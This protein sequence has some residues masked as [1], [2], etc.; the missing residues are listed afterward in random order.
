MA[1]LIPNVIYTARLAALPSSNDQVYEI[2]YNTGSGTLGDVKA[3]MM[4]Y[5]GTSAGAF[6]LGMCRVRVAPDGSKIYIGETSEIEWA[7]NCYLTIVDDFD[8]HARHVHVDSSGTLFMDVDIAFSDQHTAFSPVPVLGSHAVVWLTGATVDVEFDASDSWVFDSTISG[9][10]WTAPGASASSGMTSATPTITYNAAGIYRVLCTVTAANAKTAVGVRYV[11]VYDDDN[12]PATVFQ[13]ANC[14]GSVDSG[15]WMFDVTMQAEASLSEIRERTLVILFAKDYYNGVEQSI[16][17]IEGRENIIAVGRVGPSESIRWDPV[18]GQVHF[19]VYGPH[20]WMNKMKVSATQLEFSTAPGNWNQVTNLSV[21]RALW[22]LMHWR[23]TAT[24]VMDFYPSGDTRYDDK[25]ASLANYLWSQLTEIAGTKIMAHVLCDRYGRMFAEID[26]QMVPEVSRSAF[27]TVMT[28]TEDDWMDVI[29]FE[30]ATAHDVGQVNLS[31]RFVNSSGASVTLYSL[32]PGHLP[33]RYGEAAAPIDGMLAAS[34]AQSNQMAGLYLGWKC[35]PFPGIPLKLPQNNRMIDICPRQ[36]LDITIAAEDTPRGVPYSGNII[37]R[38]VA[39]PYDADARWLNVAINSEGET[40]EEISSNGDVPGTSG[41]DV[42]LSMPPLPPLPKLPNLPII[43]P[44][45]TEPSANGAKKVMIHDANQG[46][47]YSINFD[48]TP[49]W[50]FFNAGLTVAQRQAA[51]FFFRCPSGACYCG[52]VSNGTTST[53]GAFVAR[54]PSLGGTWVILYDVSNL[55]LSGG[56]RWGVHGANYNPLVSETVGLV[57]YKSDDGAPYFYIGSGISFAK[58][59]LVS[60]SGYNFQFNVSYGLGKWMVSS[61]G[62]QTNGKIKI[63]A[64]NGMAVTANPAVNG[65]LNPG[66]VRAGTTGKTFHDRSGNGIFIGTD[67]YTTEDMNTDGDIKFTVDHTN[68]FFACDPTGTYCM[69]RY[70]A[71]FRGRS[72]DGGASWGTIPNLPVQNNYMFAYA[73]SSQRWV[74]GGGSTIYSTPDFGNSWANKVGNLTGLIPI[75]DIN[76]VKVL[77]Y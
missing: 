54:A 33:R 26:P 37:P 53:H 48:G 8:I 12:P 3:G 55:Q 30:R 56:A 59:A 77:E 27:P 13:I 16:G 71:G 1:V 52:H 44:G 20:Y 74:A 24:M 29:E 68:N 65:G 75:P 9:Y 64:S 5:V 46:L 76:M 11:F 35:N 25:T 18:A 17:P 40:F 39:L 2:T 70:G 67:N 31:T 63:L 10:V 61:Y 22:H 69:T 23:S 6:D 15:G 73:G 42:D 45:T 60:A 34:Q 47:L 43:L 72:S 28:V 50:N 4:L 57:L 62:N 14:E 19:S 51:N 32:A 21:D 49:Q 7:S 36:F 38:R 66:H 58:G 41:V